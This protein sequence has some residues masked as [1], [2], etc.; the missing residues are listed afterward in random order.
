MADYVSTRVSPNTF[1]IVFFVSVSI[2]LHLGMFLVMTLSAVFLNKLKKPEA[3]NSQKQKFPFPP[4]S[5]KNVL[6]KVFR[7]K[8]SQLFALIY[9]TI[10]TLTDIVVMI[11]MFFVE[12]EFL[13]AT[14]QRQTIVSWVQGVLLI[15][16]LISA[17]FFAALIFFMGIKED[18][19]EE[20]VKFC[21]CFYV[22]KFNRIAI[23]LSIVLF[24]LMLF[25]ILLPFLYSLII[26]SYMRVVIKNA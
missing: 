2:I 23:I 9:S 21:Q 4:E 6:K 12:D 10:F 17:L 3:K 15:L 26:K 11:S 1:K 16:G 14:F 8:P 19:N 22:K 13:K 20:I 25:F 7:T 24:L 18:E 5:L